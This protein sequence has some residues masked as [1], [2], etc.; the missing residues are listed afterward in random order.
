MNAA[1]EVAVGA[2]LAGRVGFLDI[3]AT[4][5]ETLAQMNGAGELAGCEDDDAVEWALM[6]DGAARRVAAQVLSR[7]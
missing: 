2:F 4:V 6:V 3:A 5:Q 1:N 7:L